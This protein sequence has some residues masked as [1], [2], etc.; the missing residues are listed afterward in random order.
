M[1][2]GSYGPKWQGPVL[3]LLATGAGLAAAELV[4][5]LVQ[6]TS[7]PVVPVGQVF[8]D[9]VPRPLKNWAIETFGTNDKAVLVFGALI[10][11][12][13]FGVTAGIL[14]V[15]GARATAYAIT[16]VV[17]F[18]G[19]FAVLTRPDPTFAKLLPT[20]VGTSVSI[21]VLWYLA[22]RPTTSAAA[23]DLAEHDP[24]VSQTMGVDRRRF[25][26]GAIGI[27]SAAVLAGGV[28]RMLQQRFEVSG[29]RSSIAL[30]AP[31]S[32]SNVLPADAELA[33]EG[34]TPFVTPIKDF[35]R[36]D[37][38]LVVP[39]VSKDSWSLKIGGMVDNP[40]EISFADL[41]A[42]PQ[43]ERYVTLSCVSNPVG[44]GYI[45]NALWQGVL[46]KDI[47]DEAGVQAGATQLVSRSV[48]GWTAG[49]PTEVIMDGRDA[50]LAIAM[51]G[52]PLPARN[53]YPVRMVVP[54]LYGYVS[55]TKWVTDIELTRWE[56]YDAYWIPRGWSK[57]GPIKTMARIDT[58]RRGD[59]VGEVAIGGVAWAIHRGVSKVQVR[60]DEGEWMDAELGGAPSN[61]T[62]VQWVRRITPAPGK[63]VI[64]A[65][66]FDGDGVP[67]TEE[68]APV[69]P[70]GAQGYPRLTINIKSEG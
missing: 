55:A 6:G 2:Q 38:A 33:V 13:G 58:P 9:L 52:E 61:D 19:A 7:S 34:L 25:V 67:Q 8:I 66:A 53:G 56:D 18:L 41:L 39:Q 57:E 14:A 42:R 69:A 30:P 54:G 1:N 35:Y 20:L 48:D 65:R 28:G 16:S 40:L 22:P 27:G 15:R 43:V 26:G 64:E 62:W 23:H 3:G 63:H 68:Y 37:T 59:H 44:G 24:T 5:G 10:V 50:M 32:P 49:T 12:L 36:I 47:L 21:A 31:E 4:V 51:N 70:N 45:G 11:V 29:E 17:G 60:V 46:L